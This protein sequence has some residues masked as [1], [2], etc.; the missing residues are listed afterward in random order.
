MVVSFA[1]RLCAYAPDAQRRRLS[2]F[3]GTVVRRQRSFKSK[4]LCILWKVVQFYWFELIAG[5]ECPRGLG[6]HVYS[7]YPRAQSCW[8]P[9]C[10][11][12]SAAI[13]PD[14]Y[15]L[16]KCKRTVWPLK[17]SSGKRCKPTQLRG[18]ALLCIL[19]I[20]SKHMRINTG[21]C[22]PL[23]SNYFAKTQNVNAREFLLTLWTCVDNFK[24]LFNYKIALVFGNLRSV[25]RMSLIC[26]ARG[27][28]Y[29]ARIYIE[30]LYRLRKWTFHRS[31]QQPT[32]GSC[33]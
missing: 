3:V 1:T 22:L 4:S 26:S 24:Q 18:V 21:I 14:I 7:A 12:T 5:N 20:C 16:A 6:L 13:S 17:P 15:A 2:A 9:L 8:Q 27:L 30:R 23:G 19:V 10:V 28:T 33:R 31:L 11:A 29:A 32:P 25:A